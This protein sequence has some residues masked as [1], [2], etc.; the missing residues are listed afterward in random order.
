M[1]TD[2]GSV[3]ELENVESA[4]EN[5]ESSV[6]PSNVLTDEQ[7]LLL[8]SE[9]LN[10][11]ELSQE[12]RDWIKENSSTI[13]YSNKPNKRV[14]GAIQ[15]VAESMSIE[16]YTFNPDT[17]KHEL[18]AYSGSVY[19]I[20]VRSFNAQWE[21]VSSVNYGAFLIDDTTGAVIRVQARK[22][23]T[24]L[25]RSASGYSARTGA[26]YRLER[27]E[28]FFCAETKTLNALQGHMFSKHVAGV[29]HLAN[30]KPAVRTVT[31][32]NALH[33]RTK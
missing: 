19:R 11:A 15:I 17:G 4:I 24:G 12:L 2:N 13:C 6:I 28:Q 23:D 16:D 29:N 14:Y 20:S 5:E 8:A 10:L 25:T 33:S 18:Q 1:N 30:D 27:A 32:Y 26:T 22:D 9:D 21:R 7:F 31:V 3:A